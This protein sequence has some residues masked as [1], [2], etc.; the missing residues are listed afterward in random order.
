MSTSWHP[1]A[2]YSVR[3]TSSVP[4]LALTC[5]PQPFSCMRSNKPSSRGPGGPKRHSSAA[6][7]SPP[8]AVGSRRRPRANVAAA[9]GRRDWV[10]AEAFWRPLAGID[11]WMAG[12]AFAALSVES[13]VS[14]IIWIAGERAIRAIQAV[15]L[16]DW[17]GGC[18]RR[19]SGR[20]FLWPTR[21]ATLSSASVTWDAK[22]LGLLVG[23]TAGSRVAVVSW[24]GGER[25]D[26]EAMRNHR[27]KSRGEVPTA[28]RVRTHSWHSC[29]KGTKVA[30]WQAEGVIDSVASSRALARRRSR[31]HR[32]CLHPPPG[33]RRPLHLARAATIDGA[34]IVTRKQLTLESADM[35]ASAA[36]AE[37]K[38]KNFNDISVS[39][40]DAHRP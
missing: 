29:A 23:S 5:Q 12:G 22:G 38:S 34:S 21:P 36:I 18:I 15:S 39:V 2:L 10:R 40:L 8:R 14:S 35:M 6:Q 26:S 1:G 16:A 30:A 7:S 27:R 25:G 33:P 3:L 31:R 28:T 24:V 20:T 17:R 13:M 19:K 4:L 11:V 32:P 9:F 37:A